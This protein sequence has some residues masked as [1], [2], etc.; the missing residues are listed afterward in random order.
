MAKTTLDKDLGKVTRLQSATQDISRQIAL[1]GLSILFLVAVTIFATLVVADGPL[2]IYAIIGAVVAGYL[3][4]NIG[5][6]DVANN[7]GPAVGSKALPMAAALVIAGICEAAGAILAG[8]D[9]VATVSKGIITP[10]ADLGTINFI[11]V[12]TA[13]LFAAAVWINLATVIGAPV[14]TTH[15]IVGAVLGSG[16]AAAGFGVV[17]WPTLGAI[18]ASWVISPV[19]GGLVAAGLLGLIKVTILFRQDRIA[20]AR[21]WVPLL[22]GLMSGVFTLYMLSKGLSRIWSPS[23]QTTLVL[24]GALSLGGW[25]AARPWVARRSAVMENRRKE[26]SR[27]FVLPLICAAALLSFAHGANDVA[28]A[29]GPLAAIVSAAQTGSATTAGDVALPL[30]VLAIGA[31][32]ISLGLALFGPRLIRTVGEEITKMDA[33]RAYCVAQA[34]AITVLGA[35]TLGLPVS[36]THIAIGGIFGVGL[37]R[38]ILTNRG[39]RRRPNGAAPEP[40]DPSRPQPPAELTER[41]REKTEKRRLV[42]RRHAWSIAAAWVVTVPAAGVLAAGMY[43]LLSVLTQL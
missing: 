24:A 36:S 29:V 16:V 31:L 37:L 15:S 3:A 23:G 6:N 8:G 41:Q 14:S 22:I 10:P 42:R 1:P 34:A 26:V 39:V 5:A 11:L 25:L 43:G 7:M 32:G 30:W 40:T 2:A 18:A 38:E 33:I 19:L 4:L 13:A 9:V 21:T 27:L 17:A 28:N 12:M 35:S 20:A